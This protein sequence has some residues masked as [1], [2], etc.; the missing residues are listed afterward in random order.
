MVKGRLQ[1]LPGLPRKMGQ[2]ILFYLSLL[3]LSFSRRYS[4]NNRP[5]LKILKIKKCIFAHSICKI[6]D[7]TMGDSQYAC[8]FFTTEKTSRLIMSSLMSSS[9]FL[10]APP[11]LLLVLVFVL[12]ILVFVFLVLVLIVSIHTSGRPPQLQI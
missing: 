8:F 2:I 3:H 11:I 12:L 1:S 7:E 6:N 5:P 10:A 9:S 4:V